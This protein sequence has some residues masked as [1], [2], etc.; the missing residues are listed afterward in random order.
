MPYGP[1]IDPALP[2]PPSVCLPP[3]RTNRRLKPRE[4]WEQQPHTD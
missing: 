2:T 3:Q 1:P 4:D